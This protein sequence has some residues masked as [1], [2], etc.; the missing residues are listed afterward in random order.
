MFRAREGIHPGAVIGGNYNIS[1]VV[2]IGVENGGRN[3]G[4][5]VIVT[6]IISVLVLR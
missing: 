3:L 4:V 5:P 6:E 1:Q 2:A